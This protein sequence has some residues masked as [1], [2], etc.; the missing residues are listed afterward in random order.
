[1]RL[2]QALYCAPLNPEYKGMDKWHFIGR[3]TCFA[4]FRELKPKFRVGLIWMVH[5][6]EH[7]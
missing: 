1:M 3:D 7:S 5:L 6:V 4:L 2:T